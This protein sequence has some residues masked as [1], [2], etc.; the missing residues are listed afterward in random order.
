MGVW[1]ELVLL[2]SDG[3]MAGA[4]P[5]SNSQPLSV[6]VVGESVVSA[7]PV[8]D[9]GQLLDFIKSRAGS[10]T[11]YDIADFF[12]GYQILANAALTDLDV[13]G[14][15]TRTGEFEARPD[16]S[17]YA[18]YN[19]TELGKTVD[20][21]SLRPRMSIVHM[22][23]PAITAAVNAVL[24]EGSDLET[25]IAKVLAGYVKEQS[26]VLKKELLKLKFPTINS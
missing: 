25:A 23:L 22:S 21:A 20:Y 24:N 6:K 1:W 7:K 9:P 26:D 8:Y 17:L 18:Q 5:F 13:S 12:G 14:L 3:R 11:H 15:V 4:G 2:Q 16:G 10:F 19:L